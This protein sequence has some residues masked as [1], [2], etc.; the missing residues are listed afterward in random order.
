M[1]FQCVKKF[2]HIAVDVA[3]LNFMP[4]DV[5]TFILYLCI[6]FFFFFK[7]GNKR[8]LTTAI[9]ASVEC[10]GLLFM[11]DGSLVYCDG[12]GID[13]EQQIIIRNNNQITTGKY[14]DE[15]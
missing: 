13:N 12:I 8:L 4:L 3:F 15:K 10:C 6:C 11:G 14:Y 9:V 7:C 2:F 1:T 5:Y